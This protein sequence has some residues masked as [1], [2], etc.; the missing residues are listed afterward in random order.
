MTVPLR[1][2]AFGIA[3]SHKWT[4]NGIARLNI[5][6]QRRRWRFVDVSAIALHSSGPNPPL[7]KGL[8][9]DLEIEGLAYG[10]GGFARVIDVNGQATAIVVKDGLPGQTVRAKIVRKTSKLVEATTLQILRESINVVPPACPH[11]GRGGCGGCKT[12]TLAYPTQLDEKQ[13]QIER[14][15]DGALRSQ[16]IHVPTVTHIVGSDEDHIFGYRNKMDFTVST[17]LWTVEKP[18]NSMSDDSASLPEQPLSIGLHSRGRFDKLVRTEDCRLHDSTVG[19]A[20]RAFVE[21]RA[22]TLYWE[23]YD[24]IEH[25]G[26]FRNLVVRTAWNHLNELEAMVNFV[27][28]P[29]DSMIDPLRDFAEDVGRVF[30]PHVVSVVWNVTTSKGGSSLGEG[31]ETVLYGKSTIEQLLRGCRFQISSNSFFQPNPF[32]AEKLYSRIE[33]ACHLSGNETVV[34]LFCGTGSIGLS[35]ARRCC[36]VIGLELVE[37]AVVDARENALRNGINNAS[38]YVTDLDKVEDTLMALLSESR[39]DV[40]IVDPPRSGLHQDLIRKF[41]ARAL[42]SR[43]VYVSCNP[44]SQMRDIALLLKLVGDYRVESIQPV[45]MFPH[46]PHIECVME[47]IR[48]EGPPLS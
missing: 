22:R 2:V 8:E 42:P 37:S 30:Y 48:A 29:D 40:V 47:L 9:L 6:L 1:T 4:A 24:L 31:Q 32:Q 12:Q 5:R 36:R 10:G 20:I 43:I 23:A 25:K 26:F 17:R 38:F 21:D 34:D 27:T 13:A 7:R 44:V 46:T 16:G 35:L 14:L 18:I 39:I 15:V 33:M 28:S 41:L 3:H 19:N 45:D 11:F